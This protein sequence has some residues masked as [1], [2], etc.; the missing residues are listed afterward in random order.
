MGFQDIWNK[1]NSG[2][3]LSPGEMA[4]IKGLPP[5]PTGPIPMVGSGSLPGAGMGGGNS[6]QSGYSWG[7]LGD[8]IGGGIRSVGS[9]LGKNPDA[10]LG[11]LAFLEGQKASKRSGQLTEAALAEQERRK[12]LSA[13]AATHLRELREKRPV[14]AM[15]QDQTNP[16]A[17]RRVG[18]GA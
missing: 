5:R 13:G 14:S 9:W 2:Q 4:A 7:E 17:I 8:D 6:M 15:P 16:Y 3:Q 11:A 10:I 12:Q 1:A 18:R